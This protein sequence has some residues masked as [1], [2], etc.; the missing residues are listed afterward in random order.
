MSEHR[1]EGV[2]QKVFRG[3][4]DHGILT[5]TIP[6]YGEGWGQSFGN[7]C[8]DNDKANLFERQLCAI[9]GV[10]KLHKLEGK[11]CFVLRC[12]LWGTIEGLEN[13]DNGQR[14]TITD[15]RRSLG[16]TNVKT[17]LEEKREDLENSI[18][19]MRRSIKDFENRI[20]KLAKDY[21]PWSRWEEDRARKR[22]A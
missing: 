7:L 11:R 9:F 20:P 13:P 15:F 8:L 21:V 6:V 14:F 22:R 5:V 1:E 2:I 3:K 18:A 4:E 12:F 10:D 17:P 19:R 16:L